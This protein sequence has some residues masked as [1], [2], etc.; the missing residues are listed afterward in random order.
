MGHDAHGRRLFA[1]IKMGEAGQFPIAVQHLRGQFR[2]ANQD[3]FVV[4]AKQFGAVRFLGREGV[5]SG[6]VLAA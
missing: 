2:P 6:P 1:D 4:E 5:G 3:H